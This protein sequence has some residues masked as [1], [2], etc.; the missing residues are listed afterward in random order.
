MI[1]TNEGVIEY[2]HEKVTGADD[3]PE[4]SPEERRVL[5]SVV[6]QLNWAARQ[7]RYD[8]AFGASLV[9]QLAGQG[10]AEEALKWVNAAVRRAREEIEVVVPK[11]DCA[12][13]ELLVVSVSDTAF[14]AMPNGSSQGGTMVMFADPAILKG[15]VAVCI[16]EAASTKIQRVVRCS[17]FAE[18]SSL[19]TAFEHGDYVRAVLAELL[20]PNFR[21]DRWKL[22]A[23]KWRHILVMDAK[24]GYD[25]VS[26][27]VLPS[28]RKIAIDV[29]VLRQ[30][31]LELDATNFIRWVP[32]SEM[33][34]DGLTKW[35]HNA[36]LTRVMQEGQWPKPPDDDGFFKVPKSHNA[37]P[38]LTAPVAQLPLLTFCVDFLCEDF[39]WCLWFKGQHPKDVVFDS[40]HMMEVPEEGRERYGIAAAVSWMRARTRVLAKK[41]QQGVGFVSL[42]DDS[43]EDGISMSDAES[44]EKNEALA[45]TWPERLKC[46]WAAPSG[47]PGSASML[48]RQDLQV[49]S[50]RSVEERELCKVWC[51]LKERRIQMAEA[52]I[53]AATLRPRPNAKGSRDGDADSAADGDTKPAED[54]EAE[55]ELGTWMTTEEEEANSHRSSHGL[56]PPVRRIFTEMSKTVEKRTSCQL[57]WLA[58][59]LLP[60]EVDPCVQQASTDVK[61][62][63][64]PDPG[65]GAGNDQSGAAGSFS[66]RL[67]QQA[68]ELG[69]VAR[70]SPQLQCRAVLRVLVRGTVS[71]P[72]AEGLIYPGALIVDF[73]PFLPSWYSWRPNS[74]DPTMLSKSFMARAEIDQEFIDRLGAP[75]ALAAERAAS[76]FIATKSPTLRSVSDVAMMVQYL[77]RAFFLPGMWTHPNG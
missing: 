35:A 56:P 66:S 14:G 76:F 3:E 61:R 24:T 43:D 68:R 31:L 64:V 75:F 67:L 62:L 59:R 42:D 45:R 58:D 30:G 10:K 47:Q 19:A 71:W 21:M 34:G 29:G 69:A 77:R 28:D 72:G 20:D 50:G 41:R 33:P 74:K 63:E 11:F 51:V 22:S 49:S 16:M 44:S 12:L 27:E 54:G 23:S 70:S 2:M 8:V 53:L 7:G 4:L 40:W 73:G 6:G 48:A 18:V 46:S 60:E 52:A 55:Q 37:G 25:A 36:V 17:M 26:C 1:P 39:P 9:Q 65:P 38:T 32:G 57:R 13:E 5:G 15:V